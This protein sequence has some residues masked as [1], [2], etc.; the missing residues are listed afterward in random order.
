MK[1]EID[2]YEREYKKDC[3][4]I[5]SGLT[6]SKIFFEILERRFLKQPVSHYSVTE[7]YACFREGENN[8]IRVLREMYDVGKTL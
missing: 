4:Q 3:A 7:R 6:N 1:E 5:S 2:V 8:I